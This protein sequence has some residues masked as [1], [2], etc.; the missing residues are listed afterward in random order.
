M[1]SIPRVRPLLVLALALLSAL[2]AV[3][4]QTRSVTVEARHSP[5][6]QLALGDAYALVIG[7]NQYKHLPVLQTAVS[8][9]AAVAELLRTKYEFTDVRLLLNATRSDILRAL[10]RYREQLEPKDRLLIYYAGH[11]QL[12]R[13]AERGYWLPVDAEADVDVDWISN[14]RITDLMKAMRARHVMIVAD[15]C[16]SGT[17]T[18]GTEGRVRAPASADDLTWMTRVAGKRARTALVSGG[19]EPVMDGGRNGH[20]VFASAFL[21]VLRD[22]DDILDGQGLFDRLKG[23]VV[24]N[25]DQTPAYGDVRNAYHEG[26][27]FIFVP[28]DAVIRAAPQVAALTSPAAPAF[29]VEERDETLTALKNAN[30]RSEP[31]TKGAKLLTLSEDSA[32]A[33]TGKVRGR[34]WL[35]VALADGRTG[36]VWERLLGEKSTALPSAATPEPSRKPASTP[37][38]IDPFK[39]VLDSGLTL[40]DW[41]MLARDRLQN[42]DRM[43]VLKEAADYRL[44]YGGFPALDALVSEGIE[45]ELSGLSIGAEADTRVALKTL[46]TLEQIAGTNLS[47]LGIRAKAYHRLEMYDEAEA[48]YRIWVGQAPAD[49]PERKRMALGLFKAQSHE[50]LRPQVGQSFRDCAKCPELVVVPPGSFTMG[51]SAPE[52][53]WAS[54]G[55]AF[56][57]LLDNETPQHVVTIPAAFAV[58]KHEVTFA[59]WDACVSAGGCSHRPSD[60]GWG[61]GRRPVINVSWDDAKAYVSWLSRFT[62][63]SYRLLSEAEWEY[64]ARA[65]TTSPFHTGEQITTDQAN[66]NGSFIRSG[67]DRSIYRE[68]TL[69]VGSFASNAFGL[70]DIHGNVS[71]LVEDCYLRNYRGAPIDGKPWTTGSCEYRVQRGGSW[72]SPP[73]NLRS[74]IRHGLQPGPISRDKYRGFRVARTLAQ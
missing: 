14:A 66:F 39:V 59:E 6:A 62:G 52:R 15:S 1:A 29:A 45:A 11:G 48:A 44:R 58:G 12:D 25:A 10:G 47:I 67:S 21:D 72:T 26:G 41:T 40:G 63:K 57:E 46:A 16:Y 43:A 38:P 28:R 68:Q 64:A 3:A 65:G 7:N 5:A 56:F 69:P 60:E 42:G 36:Y 17:L 2:S 24:V 55:G 4:Q 22:N 18:R 74:A 70:H 49:H 20:S 37:T 34:D 53:Q 35:R 33:V 61:R 32:V 54:G 73:T 27:D 31:G 23:R 9:A 8:D 51:S 50:R 13:E 30:V 19:L 71:E